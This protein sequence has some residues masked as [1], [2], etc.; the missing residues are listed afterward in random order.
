MAH[1]S[2]H[3][4]ILLPL[5]C[6]FIVSADTPILLNFDRFAD[7]TILSSGQYPGV[8]FSNATILTAGIS[9]NEFEFPPHS[10]GN[11]VLDNG[12]PLT[13]HFAS[14][15][16]SFGGYVTYIEKLT[17]AAFDG[18]GHQVA[19]ALSAFSYNLACLAGPPCSGQ[20]GSSANEFL[21][22]RSTTAI[23][24]ITITGDPVGGSFT[25][26]DA[27][28][29]LSPDTTVPFGFFDT[30]V[31]NT[32]N[33]AGAVAVTGWALDNVGVAKVEV[34]RDP[35]GSEPTPSNGLVFIGTA[36]FVAGARPDVQTAY[37][38]YPYANRAGWGYMLLT[39]FLPNNGGS[40][41]RGNGTYK[42]HAI[43]TDFFGN[44][45]ELGTKA[46]TVDNAHAS[47]P[48]GTIDTP[49]QGGSASGSS[50]VNFGWALTQNPYAIPTNGSTITVILDGVPLGHPT[51][52]QNRSDIA[53]LFPGLANSNGAV[54]FFYIDT[55][56]LSNGIHT[57]SWNVYDNQNR[58]DGIGSRYFT[59][60]NGQG[61][62]SQTTPSLSSV[63]AE[64]IRP[65]RSEAT[66]RVEKRGDAR[67][68][69]RGNAPGTPLTPVNPDVSGRYVVNIHQLERAEIHLGAARNGYVQVGQ[70]R[71]PLPI[72][73]TLDP[74][75]GIFY[76]QTAAG[77][78]G[79]FDLVFHT[80]DPTAAPVQVQVRIMPQEF[81]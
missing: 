35:I 67:I 15:V 26:D 3:C 70:D 45:F 68:L 41:G 47:K 72:G 58:G 40:P 13:I 69:L 52:N 77:F 32:M 73:S 80:D 60:A 6:G 31:N 76:W 66:M 51:Y 1:C 50:Y 64:R 33:A 11:V 34:Y 36:G 4:L 29:T 55:T 63:S 30:P 61:G 44:T 38:G 46:I 9:V 49:D 20:P 14:P 7:G 71:Q 53:T 57:I 28:Y 16:F 78:L 23:S 43:A 22:V 19:A 79:N 21:Q 54:G 37:S 5:L 48:F 56:T 74:E 62:T 25:L 24:S 18:Q 27:I 17:L 39:N 12:G 2:A 8:T 10:G 65:V 75:T 81:K 42:L 59:I